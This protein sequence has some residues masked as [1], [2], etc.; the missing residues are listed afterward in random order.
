MLEVA[1]KNRA[2]SGIGDER[3]RQME[4][5][6]NSGNIKGKNSKKGAF[7]RHEDGQA[8][9]YKKSWGGK[10]NI[11]SNQSVDFNTNYNNDF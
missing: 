6:H 7:R 9:P 1:K 11:Y 4:N 10:K 5:A 8:R 2:S 3:I